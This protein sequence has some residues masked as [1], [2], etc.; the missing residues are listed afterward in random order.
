MPTQPNKP[1]ATP[2]EKPAAP[3]LI[4]MGIFAA[5]LFV[6]SLISAL[7]PPELPVP[8]PVVGLVILYVLLATHVLKL[9]Q[10]EKLG[11][12]LISLIAFL[13]VPS[14][15]QVAANLD[16]LR[17]QGIQ[18][19]IVM[20]LATIILLVCVAYTTKLMIWIRQHVFH[21]D[22]SVDADVDGDGS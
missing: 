3:I 10:V 1:V 2:A 11:D 8:T 4:Q 19:F 20:L 21:G 14:G 5:I 9:Y 7:F 13:F 18:I 22:I 15:I 16:I 12:F 17:T 6:S